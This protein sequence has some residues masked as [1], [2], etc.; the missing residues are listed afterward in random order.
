VNCSLTGEEPK[1]LS[2]LTVRVE[3]ALDRV[4]SFSAEFFL[5]KNA[6]FEKLGVSGR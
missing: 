1:D 2:V 6:N 4:L 5:L 3:P